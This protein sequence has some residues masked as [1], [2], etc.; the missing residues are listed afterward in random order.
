MEFLAYDPA[1]DLARIKVP[2]LAITGSNDIQVDPADVQ[3]MVELVP[4]D[5]E[6]HIVPGV[7]HLLRAGSRAQGLRTYRQQAET[8]ID[9][10]VTGFICKWL[11]SKGQSI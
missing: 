9:E 10:R 11:L 5:S 3:R 1:A 2:V 4:G 6:S 7:T 8:P